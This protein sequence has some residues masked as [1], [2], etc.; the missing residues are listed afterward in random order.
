MGSGQKKRRYNSSRRQEQARETRRKIILAARDLFFENGYTGSSIE[1]IASAAGVAIETVYAAF[2]NKR[3]I[4]TALVDESITGDDLPVPLLA[5]PNIE[6]VRNITDQRQVL[7]K[8]SQ[9]IY[10]IMQR[11]SPI[12]ELLRA[13]AKI[14][15]EIEQYLDGLLKQRLQGMLFLMD[16]LLRIGPLRD[17]QDPHRAAE[18]VWAISSAEVFHLLTVDLGWSRDQYVRWLEDSLTR[19]LIT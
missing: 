11:M 8:F 7:G 18:T 6:E 1:N 19:L 17:D 10:H 9:D 16:N 5:R 14:E 15:P 2:G 12:F 3:S 4:L 13:T